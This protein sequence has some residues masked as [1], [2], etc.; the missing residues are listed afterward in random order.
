MIKMYASGIKQAWCFPGF[1]AFHLLLPL[2]LTALGKF[3]NRAMAWLTTIMSFKDSRACETFPCKLCFN[4]I[5]WIASL[6]IYSLYKSDRMHFNDK[7]KMLSS[8]DPRQ[9][10]LETCIFLEKKKSQASETFLKISS[11]HSILFIEQIEK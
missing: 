9:W 6:N 1:T 3:N 2:A 4:R 11:M 10:H 5:T 7:F 8:Y